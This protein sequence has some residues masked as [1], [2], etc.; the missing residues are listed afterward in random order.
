M[1]EIIDIS[2]PIT[3]AMPVYPG[4]AATEIKTVKSGSGTAIVSEIAMTSHTGTHIDAPNHVDGGGDKSIDELPLDRFYGQCTVLDLSDCGASVDVD[5]LRAHNI[6]PGDRILLKTANSSRGYE[7]F[8]EDYVYLEGEAARYLAATGVSLVG[9]DA[10]SVKQRG[11]SDNTAH[12]ALLSGGIPLLEGL[13]L[14]NVD[15]GEYTL[16]A[17]PLAFRGIDGSPTRAILVRSS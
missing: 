16:I 17:F 13:N 6:K 1:I 15:G 4:T 14:A 3:A 9:I 8:Y 2:L 12:T 7:K 11:S 10:L 5:D